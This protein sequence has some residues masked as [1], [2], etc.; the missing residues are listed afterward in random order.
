MQSRY[1]DPDDDK[2]YAFDDYATEPYG[3]WDSLD[4]CLCSIYEELK[5]GPTER[6]FKRK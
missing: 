1:V 3:T 4:E 2:T 5:D 6:E